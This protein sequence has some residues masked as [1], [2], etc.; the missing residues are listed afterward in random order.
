MFRSFIIVIPVSILIGIIVG[1]TSVPAVAQD[2]FVQPPVRVMVRGAGP[3]FWE[4]IAASPLDSQ[5]LIICA[6]RNNPDIPSGLQA[7]LYGSNDGGETW[8]RLF[9]RAAAGDYY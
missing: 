1:I 5:K 9:R 2:V 7:V 3:H 8:R 4:T 6:L